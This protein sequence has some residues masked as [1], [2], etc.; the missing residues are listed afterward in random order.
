ME[1][2]LTHWREILAGIL[3]LLGVLGRRSIWSSCSRAID[4]GFD[5]LTANL[6]L[7]SCQ[8]QGRAKDQTIADLLS[9]NETLRAANA[10]LRVDRTPAPSAASSAGSPPS[11]AC[12]SPAPTTSPTIPSSSEP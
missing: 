5:L 11:A 7:E 9:E 10:R 2:W 6:R 3:A 8:A 12:T 1:Q 4:T